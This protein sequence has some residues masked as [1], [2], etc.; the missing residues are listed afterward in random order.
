MH[1]LEVR[2]RAQRSAQDDTALLLARLGSYGGLGIESRR[3]S[4]LN[5]IKL[6]R[7]KKG[8]YV[9]THKSLFLCSYALREL[10]LW[11]GRAA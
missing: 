4:T 7:C 11:R 3:L 6:R 5:H 8:I 9:E 1:A 2:L 10:M